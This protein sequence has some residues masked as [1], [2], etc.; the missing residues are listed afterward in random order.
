MTEPVSSDIRNR[1]LV[2]QRHA[3]G[4][5]EALAEI[6]DHLDAIDR[7]MMVARFSPD[8][9][10]LGANTLFLN[11][12]G[13]A[14]EE[15]A[16]A[17][18]E[19]VCPVKH[20]SGLSAHQ[21]LW[22]V[23]RS[24]RPY[25][26][27]VERVA[28][29]GRAVWLEVTYA[30]TFDQTGQ[31]LSILSISSDVSLRVERERSESKRLWQSLVVDETDSAVIVTDGQWRIV[32]VNAGFTR[33]FGYHL[34]EIHGRR[35][36]AL[37]VP[38]VKPAVIEE[39]ISSANAG[40]PFRLEELTFA[41][42]GQ[43]F[44]NK[45]IINPVRDTHG[46]LVN[47]VSVVTDIT[48]AKMHEVIH[49]KGLDALARETPVVQIMDM[50]CQEVERISPEVVSSILSV[51][52]NGR[53][54]ALAAPSLPEKFSRALDGLVMGPA[55]GSCGTSAFRGAEV[56][57]TDIETDPL[58][59]DFAQIALPL[60]LKACWSTPIISSKG[61]VVGTFAFYY[62]EKREPDVFHRRLVD[63][64]VNLC[65]L[66][67]EREA[68]RAEIQKLAFYDALTELPNRSLLLAKAEQAIAGA[69]RDSTPLAVLFV[70][71]DRFKQINDTL[72]HTVGD[73][74]LRLAAQSLA[75]GR[76]SSDI[77]GRLAGDEFVLVLPQCDG[78]HAAD[79]AEQIQ[80]NLSRPQ[81]VGDV[82]HVL[83]AS[84]GIS[85]FPENGEDIETLLRRA[86]IAMYE[87]KASQRG[88]FSFFSNEMNLR[89]QE[90][91]ALEAALRQAIREKQ[92][93]LFYQPQIRLADGAIY[94]VEALARWHHPVLGEISPVRFIPLAEDCGLIGELG[95]W[96]LEEACRQMADWRS[97]GIDVPVVAVNLS[98]T[99]FHNADLPDIIA[100]LLQR[101]ALGPQQLT[102]EITEN[103]LLDGNVGTLASID[104]I[105]DLGVRLSMD[106]FGTG[107]SSLSYLRRLPVSEL[108]LDKSFVRDLQHDQT[109]RALS[110]AVIRIGESLQLVVVAEGVE[111]QAQL[112]LLKQQGFHVI[113]GF[114]LSRPLAAPALEAWLAKRQPLL[115]A[116]SV[117][118]F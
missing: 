103:V 46:L 77:I 75:Q 23:L 112:N 73:D 28:R 1:P 83:S 22:R 53:M 106:D 108:K 79:I 19:L 61:H 99:N 80:I 72:G 39:A 35:P 113:Q 116:M 74:V 8:G 68:A 37:L 14:I 81:R 40:R 4:S 84:I 20:H 63:V 31:L 17:P 110:E 36:I 15:I 94:G 9:V 86:D 69:A 70:D 7:S 21:D 27:L 51:D 107:Y 109:A 58:W 115:E 60:G 56:V 24:G 82:T 85:L 32:Y 88:G 43:R 98:P 16:G 6:R 33:M 93:R 52:E 13:Y 45:M 101:F 95:L 87:A 44:W 29:D 91:L 55:S 71:L 90:R 100:E 42:D 47:T 92:L 111:D 34:D 3:S 25:S 41:K 105:R 64:C 59:V 66:A 102:L 118:S 48:E 18:H 76:R 5:A 67:L 30:P 2:T 54:H 65:A 78:N 26:G 97:R 38:H 49:H 117:G 104:D 114:L 89:A 10:F 12:F 96:V 11:S 62:R 57:V 50:I